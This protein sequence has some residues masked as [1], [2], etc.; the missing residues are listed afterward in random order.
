MVTVIVVLSA[1]SA[2]AA[3]EISHS[4]GDADVYVTIAQTGRAEERKLCAGLKID[5]I[6]RNF[7]AFYRSQ[8]VRSTHVCVPVGFYRC[9]DRTEICR[10]DQLFAGIDF[11]RC[12]TRAL[13]L[14][15]EVNYCTD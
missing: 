11:Y 14:I 15:I 9:P 7:A 8:V 10:G 12:S 1:S 3:R 2:L 4:R 5:A 13:K 6:N